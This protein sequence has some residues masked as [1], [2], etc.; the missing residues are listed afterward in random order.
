MTIALT[1]LIATNNRHKLEEY[2]EI[3]AD[4]PL[5]LT[6]PGAEGLVLDPVETGTTFEENAIIKATAFAQASGLPTLADDSGLEVDALGGEPGVFS[7]RYGDTAKDD[8][9]GRYRLLLEKLAARNIAW[10]ERTARF[11]CVVAISLAG[12][13]IGTAQGSVEGI[14]TFEPR[15]SGG[16]GYDPVFFIPEMNRTMAELTAAQKHSISHRGRAA[17][18]AI[19]L[20]TRLARAK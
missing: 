19:P 16:F 4:L 14:I 3:L 7:A 1:L 5:R 20:L 17:R 12:R 15:G 13:L 18:A 2:Q 10:A 9:A 6:H 11:R 8:H